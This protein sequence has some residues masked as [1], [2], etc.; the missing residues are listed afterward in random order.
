MGWCQ[1]V[2]SLLIDLRRAASW[3]VCVP[4]DGYCIKASC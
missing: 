2:T 1:M 3:N 4:K